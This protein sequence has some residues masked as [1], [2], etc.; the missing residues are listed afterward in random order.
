[1]LTTC[2]GSKIVSI[3]VW[4]HDASGASPHLSSWTHH[5]SVG[6]VEWNMSLDSWSSSA[7][8]IDFFINKVYEN[9]KNTP[10]LFCCFHFNQCRMGWHQIG[11]WV[12]GM[13]VLHIRPLWRDIQAERSQQWGL[14]LRGRFPHLKE[15]SNPEGE[16]WEGTKLWGGAML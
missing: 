9:L 13:I 4:V 3:Y 15:D 8:K 1:M 10:L 11:F 2:N 6:G 5:V 7:I 14:C 12:P 16:K